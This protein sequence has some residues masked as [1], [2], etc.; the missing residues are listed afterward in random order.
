MLN[1]TIAKIRYCWPSR[2]NRLQW[3]L[4]GIWCVRRRMNMLL[5]QRMKHVCTFKPEEDKSGEWYS[6]GHKIG[7]LHFPWN[8]INHML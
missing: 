8:A 1:I 4:I 6:L 7:V 5:R 2:S 3:E